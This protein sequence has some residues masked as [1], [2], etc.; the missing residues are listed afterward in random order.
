VAY[1]YTVFDQ[2]QREILP[3]HLHPGVARAC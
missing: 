1:Q 2:D 3:F